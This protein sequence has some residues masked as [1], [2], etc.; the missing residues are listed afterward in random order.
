MVCAGVEISAVQYQANIK[1]ANNAVSAYEVQNLKRTFKQQGNSKIKSNRRKSKPSTDTKDS[2]YINVPLHG[3]RTIKSRSRNK[4]KLSHFI[5]DDGGRAR[6]SSKKVKRKLAFEKK[7][8]HPVGTTALS[9]TDTWKHKQ[10]DT[11]KSNKHISVTEYGKEILTPLSG[12][13]GDLSQFADINAFKRANKRK[14][15]IAIKSSSEDEEEAPQL[16]SMVATSSLTNGKSN[17]NVFEEDLEDNDATDSLSTSLNLLSWVLAPITPSD[18][19]DQY[20]ETKP[21]CVKRTVANYYKHLL[22]SKKIDNILRHNALYYTRNV[23][24]VSYENGKR[25]THNPEGRAV[26]SAVW[27]YYQ[28]GCSVRILNPQSYCRKVQL[29]LATLQ[30]CFGTM[31]GANVYLTPPGSQGF[32]PHYDDIE[33]FVLQLEGRKHW[34]LYSPK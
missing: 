17:K 25:E 8:L 26:P 28:N 20:W 31:V 12:N 21:L 16:V 23:D 29:L 34:K 33:A 7:E 19:F 3:K 24:V 18:F 32:A 6:K 14:K 10:S 1:M 27:D 13:E 22:S 30:E 4:D 11:R 9:S 5:N 15:V 2:K